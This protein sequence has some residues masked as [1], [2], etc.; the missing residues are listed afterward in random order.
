MTKIEMLNAMLTKYS[1]LR[2]E[3]FDLLTEMQKANAKDD[4]DKADTYSD[5]AT[6]RWYAADQIEALAKEMFPN[7]DLYSMYLDT[8]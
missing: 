1:E 5:E 2:K 4:F 3:Y 6:F 7:T 8:I